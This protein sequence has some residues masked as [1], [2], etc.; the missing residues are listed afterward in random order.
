MSFFKSLWSTKNEQR[1]P[2]FSQHEG[3]GSSEEVLISRWGATLSLRL[4]EI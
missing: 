2:N 1:T 3:V 4:I